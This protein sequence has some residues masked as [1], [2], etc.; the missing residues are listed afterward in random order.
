MT[1]SALSY[2]TSWRICRWLTLLAV[3]PGAVVFIYIYRF[4]ETLQENMVNNLSGFVAPL[5]AGGRGTV[6]TPLK[7]SRFI[8]VKLRGGLGNQLWIYSTTYGLAKRTG[9]I[10]IICGRSTLNQLF[11]NLTYAIQPEAK[12]RKLVGTKTVQETN[13]M[14][15]DMN[16]LEILSSPTEV[17]FLCC[18]LQNRGYF[19]DYTS[20]LRKEFRIHPKYVHAAQNLLWKVISGKPARNITNT[21]Q[22]ASRG[23]RDRDDPPVYIGI[24]VRRGELHA[25]PDFRTPDKAYFT[26]AISYFRSNYTGRAIFIVVTEDLP[27][28]H[29]NLPHDKDVFFVP[30]RPFVEHFTLLTLCNHTVMSF[31]TF[32]YWA[33]WLAGGDVTYFTNWIQPGASFVPYYFKEQRFPVSWAGL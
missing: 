22:L 31:G 12:C 6:R 13:T 33:A 9:R 29:A 14:H 25:R 17:V 1:S 10:P 30:R 27:W 11:P 24:H 4:S 18:Y 8:H 3:L 15:Y 26:R 7:S 19:Y 28:C 32:S 16:I 5:V 23:P 20:D 21:T 2:L